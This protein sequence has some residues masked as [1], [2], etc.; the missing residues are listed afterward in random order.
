[1]PISMALCFDLISLSLGATVFT[2]LDVYRFKQRS[3]SGLANSQALTTAFECAVSVASFATQAT[4]CL[5]AFDA[6]AGERRIE[7]RPKPERQG[8]LQG[9]FDHG[10][11]REQH[12]RVLAQQQAA[13]DVAVQ[14]R[15]RC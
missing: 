6:G 10:R 1:M 9:S 15:L 14:G 7:S 3:S 12:T 5:G 4:S 2:I 11:V 13:L 8:P